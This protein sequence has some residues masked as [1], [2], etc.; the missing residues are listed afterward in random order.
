[1]NKQKISAYL[2]VYNEEKKIKKSLESL[3]NTVDEIVVIHDGECLDKT[4]EISKKYTDKIFV[5][6]RRENAEPHRPFAIEKCTGDWILQIDADER[7]STNLQNNLRRLIRQKNVDAFIFNWIVSIN[8]KNV[9]MRKKILFRKNKMYTIGLPHFQAETY[10]KEKYEN[11][12]L[13]HNTSEFN[14][15]FALL[16]SYFKKNKKWGKV[17][18]EYYNGNKKI[19]TF[20][21][22]VNDS[23]IK[24]KNKILLFK[25]Y[26][27]VALFVLPIYS[28]IR[29]ILV[30]YK[31]GFLGIV[32]HQ[33][34]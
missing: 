33:I 34:I 21:C 1:M 27:V 9:K 2:V 11:F 18:A 8:K 4:L 7:L 14:N 3:K 28:F 19:E 6:P 15:L 29:G 5:R 30:Y 24:Q 23:D 13:I 25:K 32:S 16:R 17:S 31:N 10:G 22:S 26:P 20:N 12:D